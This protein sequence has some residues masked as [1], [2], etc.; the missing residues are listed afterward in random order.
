MQLKKNRAKFTPAELKVFRRLS[1]PAKVQD[2]LNSLAINFEQRGLTYRSPRL[3]LRYKAAHC[4]EGAIFAACALSFHGHKPL[5]MDLL[6]LEPDV[7]HV[8][9]VF[10]Q[11]GYWGAIG[12]TNH[13]VLRYREPVYRTLRE[14]VL[15]FFHEYFLD[16]GE[17]TLRY[18]SRPVNLSRFD[19]KGWQTD[20]K[21]L[22]YIDSHLNKI[23]HYDILKPW[24]EKQLRPADLIEIAAGKL[25]EWKK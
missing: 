12:K 25:V 24:Q 8:V 23:K 18:Y 3:V 5:I 1:T 9:A 2:F 22:W 19:V 13:A 6:A 20:E 21:D 15:S 4:V 10:Q 17:K 11:R 16:S 14:L 7:S